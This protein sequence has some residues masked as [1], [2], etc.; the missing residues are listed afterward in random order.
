ML[1]TNKEDTLTMTVTDAVDLAA[2]GKVADGYAC[3]LWGHHRA[4]EMVE[5]GD[6][7]EPIVSSSCPTSRSVPPPLNRR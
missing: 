5:P 1:P 4:E 3:L 7:T 2:E 6:N